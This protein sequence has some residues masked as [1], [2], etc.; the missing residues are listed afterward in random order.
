MPEVT[1]SLSPDVLAYLPSQRLGRLPQSTA[2][3]RHKTAL[4]GSATTLNSALSISAGA[5]W[6]R[7]A[8]SRTSPAI[9]RWRSLWTTSPPS[10]HGGCAASRFAGTR[11]H[12]G[13]RR[14][15]HKD[16]RRRSSGSIRTALSA[17]VSTARRSASPSGA[18][19]AAHSCIA[20]TSAGSVSR[21]SGSAACGTRAPCSRSWRLRFCRCAWCWPRAFRRRPAGPARRCR[22]CEPG[23]RL[24]AP[25]SWRS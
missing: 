10:S 18:G 21:R 2:T 6:A 23:R 25:D 12:C 15:S 4:W 14:G 16:S 19:L 13:S 20:K 22:R 24:P 8:S 9:R 5:T 11:K 17:S 1:R 3:A 7:R